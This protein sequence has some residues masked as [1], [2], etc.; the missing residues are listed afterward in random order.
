MGK[1]ILLVSDLHLTDNPLE[2]YR[3]LIWP[4]LKLLCQQW[5][6]DRVYVL[7]DL[8]EKKDLHRGQLVN[9]VVRNVVALSR[10]VSEGIVILKG[11]HD[12]VDSGSPY[13]RFLRHLDPG[14]IHYVVEPTVLWEG[15]LFVPYAR[16]PL[17]EWEQCGGGDFDQVSVVFMHQEVDGCVTEQGHRL[18]GGL[19]RGYWIR[20]GV[21][22]RVYS[23]H[24]HK[25]QVLRTGTV[26]GGG[27]G[28]RVLVEYVGAPYQVRFGDGYVGRV[29]VVD[30]MGEVVEEVV[31]SEFLRRWVLHVSDP[32]EVLEHEGLRPGDHCKV[33]FE[34]DRADVHLWPEV[35]KRLREVCKERKVVLHSLELVV[36]KQG[37]QS[38]E[39]ESEGRVVVRTDEE[40]VREWAV[41]EGLGDQY[42]QVGL[43]LVKEGGNNTA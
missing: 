30:E 7:G 42:V 14:R 15:H 32:E 43:D 36:L 31:L 2:E 22:G 37:E 21:K 6:V 18:S 3:W 41:K 4:R 26:G 13:F 16:E 40:I 20:R 10:L 29:L 27:G 35:R 11:N 23:G 39:G 19:D 28:N 12:F 5:K 25:P 9:R 1:R 8:T 17:R 34:M 33:R 24:I 38:G